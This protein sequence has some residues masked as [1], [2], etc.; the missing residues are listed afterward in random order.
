MKSRIGGLLLG[1]LLK[2]LLRRHAPFHR[3][4]LPL[5]E[6]LQTPVGA[7]QDVAGLAERL[8][9]HDT[10]LQVHLGRRTHGNLLCLNVPLGNERLSIQLI[11]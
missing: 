5:P 9:T 2:V 11:N 7:V 1:V 6:E 8:A 4:L 3:E 10:G